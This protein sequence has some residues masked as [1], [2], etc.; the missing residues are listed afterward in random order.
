MKNARSNSAEA[1][2]EG[3][4]SGRQVIARAASILRTLEGSPQGLTIADIA[5]LS[6]LPRTTVTRLVRALEAEQIIDASSSSKVRLGPALIRL[7]SAAHL[8]AATLVRP[9]M[10][11]LSRELGE[12]VDLWI[13]R[14]DCVELIDEVASDQEVRI[15]AVP[16]FRLPLDKTAPGKVFLAGL[17]N[18]QLARRMEGRLERRMPGSPTSLKALSVDLEKTRQTGIGV[19]IEEH[20]EDVCAVAMLVKIGFVD[21]YSI[22][23]P[24]PARRFTERRSK[25]EQAL[26]DCVRQIEDKR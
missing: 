4:E 8:D 18:A 2:D 10:I 3:P 11:A 22:A 13:E 6:G 15:V 26:R 24:V 21:R 23:V 5:R 19:D 14:E 16:G 25:I 20:G 7:A 9:Y 12:T 17:D 1:L